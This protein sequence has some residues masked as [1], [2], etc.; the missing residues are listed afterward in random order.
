[1]AVTR[2]MRMAGRMEHLMVVQLAATMASKMAD[3]MVKKMDGLMVYPM[4]V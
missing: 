2:A 3:Q 1:M 4:A